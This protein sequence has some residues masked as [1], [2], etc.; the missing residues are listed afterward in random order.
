MVSIIQSRQDELVRLCR[1]F[2][3]LRLAVFGSAVRS[4]FEPE[5]SDLDFV[6]EFLPMSPREHAASYLGLANGLER[7][8]ERKIDLLEESAVRNP[9]IRRSIEASQ[10]S[11]Y[12][13]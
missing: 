2:Q 8:F 9:Y 1:E 11:I 6:V 5:T 7:I 10:E 3:V 13:A 12:A 4:D